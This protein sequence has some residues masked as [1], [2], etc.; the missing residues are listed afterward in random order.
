[1]NQKSFSKFYFL[2]YF[3]FISFTKFAKNNLNLLLISTEKLESSKFDFKKC[4]IE[5]KFFIFFMRNNY[6]W[7]FWTKV[8][9]LYLLI[10]YTAM[11]FIIMICLISLRSKSLTFFC[12]LVFYRIFKQQQQWLRDVSSI[13]TLKLSQSNLLR[14]LYGYFS[15]SVA[16]L[17]II[18]E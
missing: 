5:L 12:N 16:F 4:I 14:C 18:W 17:L 9:M 13:V 3:I 1:M 10:C 15:K 2:F 11:I 7:R 8:S 6:W